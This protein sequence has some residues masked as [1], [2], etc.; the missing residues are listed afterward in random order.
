MDTQPPPPDARI[1]QYLRQ[2]ASQPKMQPMLITPRRRRLSGMLAGAVAGTLL[3]VSILLVNPIA[4]ARL[5]LYLAPDDLLE[6]G[7]GLLSGALAGLITNW[8]S[9][10]Q[11]GVGLGALTAAVI[12]TL[13][14]AL[15]NGIRGLPNA[16]AEVDLLCQGTGLLLITMLLLPV[17]LLLRWATEIYN[18]QRRL[19]F[20]HWQRI[21]LLLAL[22][23]IAILAGT[24]TLYPTPV[25]NAL[26]HMHEYL[27][28]GLAVQTE[29][30][31]PGPL[32]G[33]DM[34]H[35]RQYATPQYTLAWEDTQRMV[36]MVGTPPIPIVVRFD[37]GYRLVCVFKEDYPTCKEYLPE[38]LLP[39]QTE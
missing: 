38:P 12:W 20:Y 16:T 19:P 10:L 18:E 39:A 4:L 25:R 35:F 36:Y 21:R 15:Y 14:S 7:I 9:E 37:N 30:D 3:S 6:I 11:R 27:S 1:S 2:V 8:G 5:P 24:M 31:L 13:L 33:E 17:A 34:H 26:A 23:G 29:A 32:S 22:E 28:E